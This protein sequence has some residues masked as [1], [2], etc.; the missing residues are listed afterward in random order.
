MATGALA[1]AGL[2][3]IASAETTIAANGAFPL[4]RDTLIATMAAAAAHAGSKLEM[5]KDQCEDAAST[6]IWS[7]G[8]AVRIAARLMN[9]NHVYRLEARW[10]AKDPASKSTSAAHFRN[11]CGLVV[12]VFKPEWTP[13]QAA[14]VARQLAGAGRSDPRGSEAR[15]S[16]AQGEIVVKQAGA[17]R[18]F[19]FRSQ[20]DDPGK[21]RLAE[22]ACGA[23]T[24]ITAIRSDPK[25]S[26]PRPFGRK[27][28]DLF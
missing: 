26:S 4:E 21:P 27:P 20:R 17:T 22:I 18:F 2:G 5:K 3:R 15:G 11:M 13:A 25:P 19:V 9:D 12:A 6:C 23:A 10:A 24:D 8:D 14:A 1:L 16:E 7:A 28:S